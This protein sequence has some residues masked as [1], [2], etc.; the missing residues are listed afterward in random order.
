MLTEPVDNCIPRHRRAGVN[1]AACQAKRDAVWKLA[2][3][4]KTATINVVAGE[5]VGMHGILKRTEA[6][7]NEPPNVFGEVPS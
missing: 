1:R 6:A 7:T 3:D 2:R 4:K 5:A